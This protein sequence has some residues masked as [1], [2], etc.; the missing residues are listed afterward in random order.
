MRKQSNGIGWLVKF[1]N[2]NFDHPNRSDQKAIDGLLANTNANLSEAR[3]VQRQW[4]RDLAFFVGGVKITESIEIGILILDG[5]IKRQEERIQGIPEETKRVFEGGHE[6]KK[7]PEEWSKELEK[8]LRNELDAL[9][10]KKQATSKLLSLN[11]S[12]AAKRSDEIKKVLEGAK[13]VTREQALRE[14]CNKLSVWGST[15][16]WHWRPRIAAEAAKG[17]IKPG[18]AFLQLNGQ[19]F[20]VDRYPVSERLTDI[21]HHIVA[22]GLENGQLARL[23]RCGECRRF[24]FAQHRSKGY[25]SPEHQR[26]HDKKEA[27]LR[28]KRWRTKMA[29][30]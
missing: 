11:E 28:A 21:V 9:R 29:E 30:R 26:R 14:L 15:T 27:R 5:M 6:I 25:C 16:K 4:E 12:E 23:R 13:F 1:L 10:G 17:Y 3:R 18:Q 2:I 19:K 7:T 20:V 8:T 24:F 22:Q